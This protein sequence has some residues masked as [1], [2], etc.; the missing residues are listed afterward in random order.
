MFFVKNVKLA[1]SH[2]IPRSLYGTWLVQDETLVPPDGT[3]KK[4]FVHRKGATRSFPAGH[5]DLK[6]TRC[7][8][9]GHPC[10]VRGSM[11]DSAAILCPLKGAR[12]SDCSVN[13]GSRRVMARGNA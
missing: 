3:T 10:L 1:R 5:P 6:G 9:T 8:D 13:H 12:Q 7:E 2:I 4:G 11:L